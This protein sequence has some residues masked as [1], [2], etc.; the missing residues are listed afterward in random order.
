MC[1]ISESSVQLYFYV[2]GLQEEGGIFYLDI[3]L[4]LGL[5]AVQVEGRRHC[6]SF[7]ELEF[8]LFCKDR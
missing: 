3:E 5:P 4:V 1:L 8:I 6:I 7:S 2:V